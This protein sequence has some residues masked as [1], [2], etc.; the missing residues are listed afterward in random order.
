MNKNSPDHPLDKN[1]EHMLKHTLDAPNPL[2]QQRLVQHVLQEVEQQNRNHE[3]RRNIRRTWVGIAAA[4]VLVLGAVWWGMPISNA[5]VAQVTNLYGHVVIDNHTTSQSI[6]E[7][8]TLQPGQRVK[9]ASG[10]Q[11]KIELNDQSLLITDP[12][13]VLHVDDNGRGPTIALEQGAISVEAPKQAPGRSIG[14]QA[15]HAHIKVLGTQLDVRLIRKPDHTEQTYV[16]VFSGSVELASAG[17]KV[18]VLPGTEAVAEKGRAPVRSS[19]VFE[20]NEL[21]RLFNQTQASDEYQ[22]L[23]AIIDFTTDTLWTLIPVEQLTRTEPDRVTLTLSHPSFQVKAYTLEGVE[24]TTRGS[25]RVLQL[26]T[27]NL[28]QSTPE[29]LLIKIPNSRGWFQT[30]A[31]GLYACTWDGSEGDPLRLVQFH[32]RLVQFHLPPLAQ[33]ENISPGIIEKKNQRNRLIVTVAARIQ[34][35]QVTMRQ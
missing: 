27:S 12:R 30:T 31:E 2:F 6:R 14:I 32:L 3:R 7:S 9:T 23:P 13:T 11:A 1:L 19:V 8:S 34:F 35:P 25:G 10:S 18:L 24:V 5:P 4:V 17:H 20:V 29:Y 28:S 21:I 33:I 22:G 26:D 15:G 16:R